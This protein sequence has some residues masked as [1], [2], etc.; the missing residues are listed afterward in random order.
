MTD[1]YNRL[2]DCSF[3]QLDYA[4]AVSYYD[5]AIKNGKGNTDYALFQK[6]L[7]LGVSGKDNDKINTLN[8]DHQYKSKF[9]SQGR[10]HVPDGGKLC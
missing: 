9:H 5:M 7:A 3:V 10:C 1:A 2:G 6:A 4:K 8:Q